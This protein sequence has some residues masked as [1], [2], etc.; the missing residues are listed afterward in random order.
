MAKIN[1]KKL[2][3]AVAAREGGVKNL[4]IA[5]IAEAMKATLDE[6]AYML[7]NGRCE[8]SDILALV[9]KHR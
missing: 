1:E 9:E 8:A 6:L 7:D 3:Q 2:A 5:Q 4:P